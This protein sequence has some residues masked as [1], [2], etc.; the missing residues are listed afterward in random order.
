[1]ASSCPQCR[2]VLTRVRKGRQ[3]SHLTFAH[4]K[5][6][7]FMGSACASKVLQTVWKLGCQAEQSNFGAILARFERSEASQSR[8]FAL[9]APIFRRNGSFHTV[10]LIYAH[11][12]SHTSKLSVNLTLTAEVSN[13]E[14]VE[15]GIAW[16]QLLTSSEPLCMLF[17]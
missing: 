14:S 10:C 8:K 9:T 16:P 7:I 12:N 11:T 2:Q 1:V 5:P 3:L 13:A 4:S 17:P 6:L 15:T